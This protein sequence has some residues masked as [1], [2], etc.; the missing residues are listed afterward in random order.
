MKSLDLIIKLFLFCLG[1]LFM[2][3]SCYAYYVLETATPKNSITLFVIG[4]M[5]VTITTYSIIK[6]FKKL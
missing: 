1:L 6:D 2:A 4:F 3:V 5:F